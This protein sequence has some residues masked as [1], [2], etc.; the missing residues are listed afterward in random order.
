MSHRHVFGFLIVCGG[1]DDTID[2]TNAGCVDGFRIAVSE[3]P[4]NPLPA[5]EYEVELSLDG[6]KVLCRATVPSHS[7]FA[8]DGTAAQ[9]SPIKPMLPERPTTGFSIQVTET[10]ATASVI[11]RHDDAVLTQQSF[12]PSYQRSAPNG[13][14]CGPIC[15]SAAGQVLTLTF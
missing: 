4:A 6:T 12:S 11:V 15:R 14:E 2:C 13:E 9:L 3:S 1:C 5:G 7:P 10:P 8:C